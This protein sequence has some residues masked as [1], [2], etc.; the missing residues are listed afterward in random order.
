MQTTDLTILIDRY[1]A[2][3]ESGMSV[4]DAARAAVLWAD[5]KMPDMMDALD[6]LAKRAKFSRKTYSRGCY[7]PP[8]CFSYADIDGDLI[9]D[10][11]PASHYPSANLRI[12]IARR[13]L[14][15]PLPA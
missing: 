12:D 13:L 4:K 11:F 7:G 1:R 2:N 6:D 8:S 3:I 14:R 9:G 5:D 15:A 10:P